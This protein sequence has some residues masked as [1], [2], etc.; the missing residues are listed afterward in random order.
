MKKAFETLPPGQDLD[1]LAR[2]CKEI[3]A[4]A[5]EETVRLA[6]IEEL[7]KIAE[8]RERVVPSASREE[9]LRQ[10]SDKEIL[11]EVDRRRLRLTVHVVFDR[12]NAEPLAGEKS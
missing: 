6:A 1:D 11:A 2:V 8:T 12:S 10:Y 9:S 4:S 7:R 5:A 3:L